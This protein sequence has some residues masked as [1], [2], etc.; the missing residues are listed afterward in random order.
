MS[1]KSTK[2]SKPLPSLR[3]FAV[4]FAPLIGRQKAVVG[5]SFAALFGEVL[6][7]LLEPWPLKFVIDN[8]ILRGQSASGEP[9]GLSQMEPMTLLT[10]AAVSVLLIAVLRA[11]VAYLATVGFAIVGN[12][13]LIDVRNQ[14]YNHIQ[15]LSLRFHGKARGGDLITRVTGDVGMLKEVLVTAFMPLLG[16]IVVL[17]GMLAVMAWLN[18]Q[19]TLVLIAIAPLLLFTASRKHKRITEVAREQRQRESALAA[20]AAESISAIKTV[21]ALSLADQF[22]D[23]FG[24]TGDQDFN[25]G[26]K[27]KRLAAG[28]ERTVDVVL[29]LAAALVLWIGTVNVLEGKLTPGEMLVFLAYLKSAF[30]PVRNWA[31]FSARIAK[32]AAAAERVVEIMDREPE[33]A[34]SPDARPM[35]RP[36]GHIALDQVSFCY[37]E[38]NTVLHDLT[39]NIAAGEHLAVMGP[40]GAGKSTLLSLFLRL[41]DP[42]GGRL[43]VDG[44]DLRNFTLASW[45]SHF[46]VVLQDTLLFV[47]TLADN[48]RYGAVGP[49]TDEDVERA[50]RIANIHDFISALP[51][52]YETKVGERGVTLSTGQ[53]QRIAIARAAIRNAPILILDE[54]LAGLDADNAHQVHAALQRLAAGRTTI[55]VTHDLRHGSEA[56]QVL[57]IRPGQPIEQGSHRELLSRGGGYAAA[58][59]RDVDRHNTEGATHA[60]SV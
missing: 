27:G 18:W 5:G 22:N 13:V 59:H 44:Q 47:G 45:R 56:D 11:S 33:V 60:T 7:R 1:D 38:G 51:E 14:L 8:V 34:D 32:A 12:R 10:I 16:N 29:A 6:L 57:Y 35:P 2:A 49:A 15:T 4:R 55:H 31:K 21:Q 48:I 40:S 25:A 17:A 19:L 50:A 52:G 9:G 37:E 43:L 26:V 41:Y 46:S 42:D 36:A 20:T 39:I 54:P 30:K 53:R 23:A 28:L 58:H 3:K 24:R